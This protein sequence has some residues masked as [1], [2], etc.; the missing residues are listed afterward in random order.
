MDEFSMPASVKS[1]LISFV[2]ICIIAGA[3]LA[4]IAYG[5]G[6]RFDF[7]NHSLNSTGL[8]VVQSDP[9]G[10]QIFVNNDLKSATQATIQLSPDW[11]DF[12]VAKEGFQP[13]QKRVQVQGEVVYKIDAL[14]LPVNPSLTA[15][16]VSGVI[17][18]T[19]S[20][21]GTKLA[22]V[23]PDQPQAT[24]SGSLNPTTPGI[25]I[26][27]LVDKPLGLNRDARQIAQSNGIDFSKSTLAWSPDDKQ[28]LTTL[29]DGRAYLLDT[30]T[31]NAP[32]PP[33][34]VPTVEAQW[35]ILKDQRTKEQLATLPPQFTA[36]ASDSAS[37]LSLS[38][39]ETK[40]LYEATG[41]AILPQ[42]ITPPLIGTDST[43]E[44][45]KVTPGNLYIY[46]VK[47]DRNYDIGQAS[48]FR[49]AP[50][51]TPTPEKFVLAKP[52]AAAQELPLT[53]RWLPSSRHLVFVA[54]DRIQIMDYDGTNRRT[55]YAGPFWDSF[56]VP[57]ASGGK[58]VI[59]T[60]LNQTASL[61][62]NLYVVNLH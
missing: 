40:I 9:S 27:D 58:I 38:P 55:A 17:T 49:S 48:E 7:T 57:W 11:Y 61:V 43:A 23:V 34:S 21:D 56:A 29:P 50:T 35:Q 39:D 31:L 22:Y 16:T 51:P 15:L 26:L 42:I 44:T 13:W 62:N 3:A 25:W 28:L 60:N 53:I 6:Y 14:L 45:R 18:P 19:L 36:M 47:E 5:R 20:P 52:E 32:L 59:L 33:A 37:I 2:T 4:I 10:A 30:S 1:F 24:I 54:K 46:D 12:T 8:V 41:D